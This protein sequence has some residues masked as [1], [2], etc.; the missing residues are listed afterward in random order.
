MHDVCEFKLIASTFA[1][2]ARCIQSFELPPFFDIAP[3]PDFAAVF[4]DDPDILVRSSSNWHPSWRNP[5]R[6][7]SSMNSVQLLEFTSK[8]SLDFFARY[9][10]P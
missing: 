9:R 1:N 5:H 10:L 2:T 8:D 6:L 7:A 4:C 3:I